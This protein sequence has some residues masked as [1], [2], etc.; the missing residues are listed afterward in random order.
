MDLTKYIEELN[1]LSDTEKQKLK[2][3]LKQFPELL[4]GGLGTLDIEPVH[5]EVIPGAKPYHA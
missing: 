2:K 5:L 1:Y 3:L 4:S